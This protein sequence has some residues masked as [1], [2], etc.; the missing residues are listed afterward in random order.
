MEQPRLK[1]N[2]KE[3]GLRLIGDNLY[4]PK[5]VTILKE[6]LNNKYKGPKNQQFF[7]LRPPS[8]KKPKTYHEIESFC[9]VST[10]NI[11]EEAEQL[12]G[13][14]LE[15]ETFIVLFHCISAIFG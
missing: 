7:K 15:G 3:V 9:F 5:N 13:W 12:E 14:T 6:V 2:N 4:E 10:E 1:I 11:K 8:K